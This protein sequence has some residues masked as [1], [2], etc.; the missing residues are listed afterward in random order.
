MWEMSIC[1]IR[2]RVLP[3]TAFECA[4]SGPSKCHCVLVSL[5][6]ARLCSSLVCALGIQQR[7]VDSDGGPCISL[8]SSDSCEAR[9]C[10]DS[11]H[12]HFLKFEAHGNWKLMLC[13]RR[14]LALKVTFL[15][16]QWSPSTDLQLPSLFRNLAVRL[17]CSQSWSPAAMRWTRVFTTLLMVLRWA[18]PEVVQVNMGRCLRLVHLAPVYV[19]LPLSAHLSA[20]SLKNSL[21]CD[22][23][24]TKR[25]KRPKSILAQSSPRISRKMSPSGDSLMGGSIPSPIHFWIAIRRHLE[26]VSRIS[27][28]LLLAYAIASS[29]AMHAA[30]CSALWEEEP[31]SSLPTLQKPPVSPSCL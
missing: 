31:S 13:R 15:S 20:I 8:H 4:W 29:R 16:F 27:G 22:L 3:R 28:L 17:S 30:A 25:V 14:R 10:S 6:S 9:H 23:I 21:L 2:L 24:L 7:Q 18:M 12:P 26:S 1:E 11:C 5:A 19:C